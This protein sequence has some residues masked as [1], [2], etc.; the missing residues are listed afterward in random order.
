MTTKMM[1]ESL[2]DAGIVQCDVHSIV[3]QT[4]SSRLLMLMLMRN[5]SRVL[6][7]HCCVVRFVV[8]MHQ[9]GGSHTLDL[10][11]GHWQM[12]TKVSI[13]V[14]ACEALQVLDLHGLALGLHG[15]SHFAVLLCQVSLQDKER[16]DLLDLHHVLVCALHHTTRC[17]ISAL[18]CKRFNA[19]ML[20]FDRYLDC[21]SNQRNKVW[22]S[23]DRRHI[24]LKLC[25]ACCW[26]GHQLAHVRANHL[27][28]HQT[29]SRSPFEGLTHRQAGRQAVS[30]A[31]RQSVLSMH[32]AEMEQATLYIPP[33]A[34][35]Q[36]WQSHM[37]GCLHEHVLD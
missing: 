12:H 9:P 25:T 22:V 32:V 33:M 20:L 1:I 24:L 8:S 29:V 21:L 16:L 37:V 30:Q 26:I 2:G 34:L 6:H 28:C 10:L 18:L 31:V 13:V 11:F 17:A 23:C 36:S 7:F 5:R 35:V 27:A 14:Q 4:R 3:N 19:P 15:G